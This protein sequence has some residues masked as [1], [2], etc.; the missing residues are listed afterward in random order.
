MQLVTACADGVVAAMQLKEY[1]RDP[2]SWSRRPGDNGA[3]RGW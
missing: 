1:F 3:E 2:V